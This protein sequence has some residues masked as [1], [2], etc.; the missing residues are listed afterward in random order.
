MTVAEVVRRLRSESDEAARSV[1]RYERE[2]KARKGVLSALERR[3]ERA[4]KPQRRAR[5]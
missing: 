5:G 1:D 3:R 2:N 4:R